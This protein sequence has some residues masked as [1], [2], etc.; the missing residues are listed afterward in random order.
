[1]NNFLHIQNFQIK[2]WSFFFAPKKMASKNLHPIM[3]NKCSKTKYKWRHLLPV[4]WAKIVFDYFS[5]SKIGL[6][7]PN[8]KIKIN[9]GLKWISDLG[10]GYGQVRL[11]WFILG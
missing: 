10:L 4:Y 3:S 11:P 5:P 9:Q 2:I 7:K 1:M 8:T 6:K